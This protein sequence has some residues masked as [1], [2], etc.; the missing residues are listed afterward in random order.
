MIIKTH[1]VSL[2]SLYK[3]LKCLLNPPKNDGV[4]LR[5]DNRKSEEKEHKEEKKEKNKKSHK[6]KIF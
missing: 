3:V 6:N 5:E 1:W 4:G 2:K